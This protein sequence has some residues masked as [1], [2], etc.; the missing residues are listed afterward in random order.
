[1]DETPLDL[2]DKQ[3]RY[4]LAIQ[5]QNADGDVEKIKKIVRK[6]AGTDCLKK[7]AAR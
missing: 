7:L 3:E 4:R 1:M 6:T 2:A 5:V